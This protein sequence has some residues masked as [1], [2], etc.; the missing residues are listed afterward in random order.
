MPRHR[1]SPA[2]RHA[3]YTV[4]G[5]KCYMCG[6]MLTMMTFEV[7]HI[8]PVSLK[9]RP[10]ELTRVLEELGLDET[11]PIRLSPTPTTSRVRR[12]KFPGNQSLMEL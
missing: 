4:H 10:E 8:I 7:E 1:F 2:E 9:D 6:A 3:V 11:L 12:W 5:E